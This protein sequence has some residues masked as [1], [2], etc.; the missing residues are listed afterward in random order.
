MSN[1]F[2]QL[3]DIIQDKS[4]T[5]LDTYDNWNDFQPWIVHRWLSFNGSDLTLW[6]NNTTN[7]LYSG[8]DSKDMWYKLLSSIVPKSEYKFIRYI[9]KVKKQ[10]SEFNDAVIS[11][12]ASNM[13]ISRREVVEMIDMMGDRFDWSQFEHIK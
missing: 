11:A 7:Q 3:K 1:I 9:K 8:V 12:I 4:G 13:D 10:P 6:L 2:S 5:L